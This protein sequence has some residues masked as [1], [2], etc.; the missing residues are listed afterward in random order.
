MLK[1]FDC[2]NVAIYGLEFLSKI[3]IGFQIRNRYVGKSVNTHW[4]KK[5]DAKHRSL[6]ELFYRHRKSQLMTTF[7]EKDVVAIVIYKHMV[8]CCKLCMIR[9]IITPDI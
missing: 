1:V 7:D 6:L 8:V 4:R 2:P 9:E 3:C 5:N